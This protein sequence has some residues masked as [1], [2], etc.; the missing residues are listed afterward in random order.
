MSSNFL[1]GLK[2]NLLHRVFVRNLLASSVHDQITFLSFGPDYIGMQWLQVNISRGAC[3]TP[4]TEFGIY[5][6]ITYR[7]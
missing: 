4:V 1:E 2:E 3:I 5:H 6:I 7:F